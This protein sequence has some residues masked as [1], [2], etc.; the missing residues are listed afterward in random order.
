M[1]ALNVDIAPASAVESHNLQF[2]GSDPIPIVY[3]VDDDVSVR[4][5]IQALIHEAGWQPLVFASARDFLSHLCTSCPSCLVLDVVLPDLGGLDLQQEIARDRA[6]IPVI[7][8]S[9]SMDVRTIVRAMKAGAMEFLT[10][11]FS[12]EMLLA[13]IRSALIRSHAIQN[14]TS[15]MKVLRERYYSLSSRE[16]EI[17]GLVV[18]G[19]M[20]KQVGTQ[21][22]ISEVTVK[23]H[24]GRVMRKMRASSFAEL[25][26]IAAR[27][28][29]PR[30]GLSCRM[31]VPTANLQRVET[32][33]PPLASLSPVAC[34]VRIGEHPEGSMLADDLLMSRLC[35][36]D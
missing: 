32:P 20:N 25:V 21:L 9:G 5:A 28:G 6:D 14:V 10:K 2:L 30:Q 24:R 19:L 16:R 4:E 29:I 26:N 18:S 31:P 1:N 13:T 3:V 17:M 33:S 7:F 27:L 15:E 8:I 12:R 23:A 34:A 36:I 35:R 22:G 11:P